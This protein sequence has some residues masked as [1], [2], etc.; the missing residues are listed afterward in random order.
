MSKARDIADSNL[1]DLTVD[2]NTLV[3]DSTNNRVGIGTTS[4]D[5]ALTISASDSQVRLYDADGTN[6]FASFQSDNGTA[7]ITSRN[8]TSHGTIAFQRY[9]GTTVAESMRI[10]SSGNVG[11]GTTS[12]EHALSVFKDSNGNRTEIGI[13]NIDQRLVLGAYFESGVAQ[14]STIQ[15]TNNAENSALSLVLQ[16]DGGN[17]GIGTTSP[18]DK[19]HVEGNI[20]LGASNRTIYTGGSGN[21][22]FQNNTGSMIFVRS[23]GSSESM[24]ID[25]SG[26]VGIGTTS[27]NARLD[28]VGSSQIRQQYTG[29]SNGFQIGQFNSSGDASINNQA[30][31]NLLLAT[32]NTERMRIDSNGNVGVGTTTITNSTGFNRVSINDTSGAILEHKVNNTATGRMITSATAVSLDAITSVPLTFKTNATERMRINAAGRV[33]V[34]D[35]LLVY[36]NL[37]VGAGAGT[38][39]KINSQTPG[40]FEYFID[41]GLSYRG[42]CDGSF[43]G[44]LLLVPAYTSGTV[45]GKK[46]YGEIIAD[47]GNTGNGNSTSWAKVIASTAYNSDKLLLKVMGSSQYFTATHKVTYSGTQYLALRFSVTGGG[48][49]NSFHAKGHVMGE[50]SNFLFMARDSEVS[51]VISFGTR[52]LDI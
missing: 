20:Y 22:I 12:P 32:N 3:I 7:K 28:V 43:G 6:Q 30:N 14:Y 25:S 36:N 31:A 2:T 11:I 8:N 35:S 17:V 34:N 19:L 9:N 37:E 44:Y 26:N 16:P 45:V 40:T 1:D 52:I 42:V 18:A 33:D 49:V 50:D 13:D 48:P 27:P 24:R 39:G 46:F 15:S 5:K 10:D 21:L 47:R 51:N 38:H 41:K 4:P 23:N 29:A